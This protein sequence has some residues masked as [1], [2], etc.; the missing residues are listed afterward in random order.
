[1]QLRQIVSV[2]PEL[3]SDVSTSDA[4]GRALHLVSSSGHYFLKRRPS[5]RHAERELFILEHLRA[6]GLPVPVHVATESGAPFLADGSDVLCLFRALPGAHF[7]TFDGAEG[8]ARAHLVGT[9]LGELH[10]ALEQAPE[11][12]G[13]ERYGPEAHLVDHLDGARAAY[14]LPRARG[15]AASRVASSHLPTQLIHRDFHLY[16]LLFTSDRVSGYLDFDMLMRGPR[17]FDVCYCSIE[18]LAKRFDEPAF[19]EY[20]LRVL[21]AVLTGYSEHIELT[22]LEKSSVASL[23]TEIELSFMHFFRHEPVPGQNAEKVLH[24]IDERRDVIQQ[25]ALSL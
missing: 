13:F 16:N 3:A 1:M 4:I 5:P 22:V 10:L 6:R 21:G 12:D 17:L 11:P 7:E 19:P 24:W 9:A 8:L 14:D 23:L 18:T 20:W 25:V 15:I 2:W